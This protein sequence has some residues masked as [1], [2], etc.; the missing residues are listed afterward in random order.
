MSA[1]EFLISTLF[2]LY[3]MVVLL[4]LWLQLARADFYNP[5]SEFIVKATHPLVGPLR[6]VLPPIGRLDTATLV[7]ALLV[8]ALKVF[9]VTLVVHGVVL[10]NP[11]AILIQAFFT[12]LY[13][14]FQL[15]FYVLIIRAILSFVSQGQNPLEQVFQQLTEPFLAPIRRVIP[16]MGGLDFSVMVAIL[17]LLFLQKLMGDLIRYL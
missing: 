13:E 16:P 1:L 15:V 14:S 11:L 8:A 5:F 10:V 7:L 6:R 4:R 9:T 3:L 2:G 17:A 12:V